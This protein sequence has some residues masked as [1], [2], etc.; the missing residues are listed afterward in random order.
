MQ[1][2]VPKLD[3]QAL[4]AAL[5]ERYQVAG[6]KDKTQI[7]QQFVAVSGYHRKSA[8]R[9]LNATGR[10]DSSV[11]KRRPSRTIYDEAVRQALQVLWEASDR[12]CSKRLK[13]LIPTLLPA[14]QRHGHLQLD[15]QVAGKLLSISA[16]SID[17]LLRER[18]PGRTRPKRAPSAATRQV[19]IRTFADWGEPEPGYM[20]MDLVAHCGQSPA[21]AFVYTLTLTDVASWLDRM[22]AAAGA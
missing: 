2:Q 17:R 8:I 22:H 5:R 15:P 13:A 20:E 12:V 21:G 6:R 19:P 7:L 14:L 4:V 1:K 3:R 9:L 18:R 10:I 11:G 16:A